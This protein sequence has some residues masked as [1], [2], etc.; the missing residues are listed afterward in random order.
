MATSSFEPE[1][2]SYN[3]PTIPSH[4]NIDWADAV[5]KWTRAASIDILLFPSEDCAES[6]TQVF[7]GDFVQVSPKHRSEHWCLCRAGHMM[8]WVDLN[9]VKFIIPNQHHEAAKP[10]PQ[11]YETAQVR[12]AVAAPPA[13]PPAKRALVSRLIGFFKKN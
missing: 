3:A 7:K 5:V 2:N 9:D 11:V 6:L 13:E 8:G 12:Q 10:E 1:T 4:N